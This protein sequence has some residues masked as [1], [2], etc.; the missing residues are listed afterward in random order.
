MRLSSE[1]ATPFTIEFPFANPKDL[2]TLPNRILQ[3]LETVSWVRRIT[4]PPGLTVTVDFVAL[5]HVAFDFVR[6]RSSLNFV[7]TPNYKVS[8][9]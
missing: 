2:N 9:K 3:Q 5:P 6:L 1:D 7:R 8:G 4:H